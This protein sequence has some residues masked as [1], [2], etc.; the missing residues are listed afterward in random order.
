MTFTNH[1]RETKA[2]IAVQAFQALISSSVLLS[3]LTLYFTV[4]RAF[5]DPFNSETKPVLPLMEPPPPLQFH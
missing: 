5:I 3:K 2:N 4:T 1:V